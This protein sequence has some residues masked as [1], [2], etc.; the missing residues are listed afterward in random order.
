IGWAV[1]YGTLPIVILGF[2]LKHRIET[3]FRSLWVIAFSFII[4]GV[5]MF[6]AERHGKRSRKIDSVTPRDGLVVGLWQALAIFPGMS[7]SGSAISGGLFVNLDHASAARFSFLLGI[8]AITAAGLFEAFKER[9]E[10][11]S[12][13]ALI[14]TLIATAVSFIVGYASIAWLIGILQKRG[15][16]PFV[17]YR[18]A[19]GVILL[20]LL[21]SGRLNPERRSAESTRAS[22]HVS[23]AHA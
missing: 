22:A 16:A 15:V 19:L 3:S 5:I 17:L 6:F 12:G 13:G 4:M 7:R 11:L 9:K 10:I 21:G 1:F 20:V 14:P 18:V 8:P 2:L 23:Q